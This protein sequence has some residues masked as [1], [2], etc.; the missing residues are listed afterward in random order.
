MVSYSI[1]P[2]NTPTST[3]AAGREAQATRLVGACDEDDKK[4]AKKEAKPA[5]E[6]AKQKERLQKRRDVCA[7]RTE[8]QVVNEATKKKEYD[9]KRRNNCFWPN[10]SSPERSRQ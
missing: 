5:E 10:D 8:E 9:R 3:G 7:D 4:A 2:R 1:F 6:V